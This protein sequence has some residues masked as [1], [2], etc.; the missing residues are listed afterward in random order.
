VIA[1]PRTFGARKLHVL[2]GS[3]EWLEARRTH[4]TAKEESV[5]RAA[6]L[7]ER[8]MDRPLGAHAECPT[9]GHRE[10]ACDVRGCPRGGRVWRLGYWVCS[11]HKDRIG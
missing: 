3:P 9:R 7:G 8:D 10:C 1:T 2:Q 11:I 5:Y 6:H 4:I